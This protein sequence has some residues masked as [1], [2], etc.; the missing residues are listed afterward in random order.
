MEAETTA[1]KLTGNKD[2][3]LLKCSLRNHTPEDI[4]DYISRN[5]GDL[6]M[7]IKKK[8]AIIGFEDRGFYDKILS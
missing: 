4:Y 3:I 1:N 5:V 6:G 2:S 8:Q 7:K